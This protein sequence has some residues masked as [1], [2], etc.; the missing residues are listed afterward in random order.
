M[1]QGY[2]IYCRYSKKASNFN[3][4]AHNP[5]LNISKYVNSGSTAQFKGWVP[6]QGSTLS[7]TTKTGENKG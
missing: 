2:E 4:C 6:E 1:L 7:L 5:D 3:I